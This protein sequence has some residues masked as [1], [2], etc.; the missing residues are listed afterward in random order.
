VQKTESTI[1]K[2]NCHN[3]STEH[4]F[5]IPGDGKKNF[6][7]TKL[8]DYNNNQTNQIRNWHTPHSEQRWKYLAG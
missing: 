4:M 6:V 2:S 5:L 7:T 8:T 3:D 1:E